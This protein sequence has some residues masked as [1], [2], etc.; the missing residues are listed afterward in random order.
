MS[1]PRP[2][3]KGVNTKEGAPCRQCK[4]TTRYVSNNKCV[5]CNRARNRVKAAQEK[6]TSDPKPGTV[7]PLVREPGWPSYVDD[8]GTR[9]YVDPMVHLGLGDAGKFE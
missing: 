7:R 5:A 6:H 9:V 3:L 2:G 1:Y 8:L 4:G